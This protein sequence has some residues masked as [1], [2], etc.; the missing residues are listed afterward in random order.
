MI[1]KGKGSLKEQLY[2]V[3]PVLD[4]LRLKKN[5]RMKEFSETQLQIA[6]ISAE[7]AGNELPIDSTS[8]QVNER[9]WTLN[10]LAE[11]KSHLQELQNEKV[12][13]ISFFYTHT[14]IL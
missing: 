12:Y 9:D 6:Q 4:D 14:L 5:E 10:K 11:L 1:T 13:Y 7:I 2:A 8:L 3:Q